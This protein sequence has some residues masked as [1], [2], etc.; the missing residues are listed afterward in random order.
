[1]FV[2]SVRLVLLPGCVR[3]VFCYHRSYMKN[4]RVTSSIDKLFAEPFEPV[5]MKRKRLAEQDVASA[6]IDDKYKST[7]AR[8]RLR[9]AAKCKGSKYQN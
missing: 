5:W 6:V 3:A 1:M 8:S 2:W 7:A 9:I 4:K